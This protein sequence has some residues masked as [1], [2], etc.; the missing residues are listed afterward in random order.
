M[1]YLIR[2]DYLLKIQFPNLDQILCDEDDLRV[3]T[4][5]AALTRIKSRLVQKYDLTEEFRDTKAF[6]FA[7]TYQAGQLVYLDAEEYDDTALYA[8]DDLTL[9]LG[10]VYFCT[11]RI[12]VAESFTPAKWE[13]LG[14]QYKFFYV[15]LPADKYNVD[16]NYGI[17]NKAYYKGRVYTCRIPSTT[18]THQSDLQAHE[19]WNIP[20]INYFPDTPIYGA[21]QWGVGVPYT[22]SSEWP[23][24][25]DVYTEGDNRNAELVEIAI[26]MTIY[27]LSPRISTQNVP[28]VWDK[29]FEYSEK[30]LKEC[31]SGKAVLDL[32]LLQPRQGNSIRMGSEVKR[33]NNY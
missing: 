11:S 16:T 27:K 19:S 25:T 3:T 10:N 4:E 28:D 12:T 2:Q 30:W 17:G 29:N 31:A 9:Y 5:R 21:R 15:S 20:L 26:Y 8:P 7:D 23:T 13:L 14:A 33:V 1:A 32:P 24:N 22:I 6:S 18:R